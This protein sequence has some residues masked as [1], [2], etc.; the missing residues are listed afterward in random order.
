MG[1]YS[2]FSSGLEQ[3]LMIYSYI[4]IVI[5]GYLVKFQAIIAPMWKEDD[6]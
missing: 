3:E 1:T 2:T 5:S 6:E 4:Y